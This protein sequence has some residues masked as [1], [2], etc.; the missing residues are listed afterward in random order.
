MWIWLDKTGKVKQYLTHG[1]SPVVGETDFQIFAYFDGL[2]TDYFDSATI[3]FRKPDQQGS[4]YPVLFMR[5]VEMPYE[6]MESDGSAS[7]FKEEHS[8]YTGFLFDF[9]DFTDGDEIIRLLDTPGLWEATITCLGAPNKTNVSGLIT[10][11]VGSAAGDSEEQTE[12]S[13]DQILENLLLSQRILKKS[14]TFYVKNSDDF[15]DKAENGKL[16][17]ATFTIGS[18]VFD[19]KTN[20]LYKIL[21]VTSN[22]ND[23]SYVYATYEKQTEFLKNIKDGTGTG[24]LNQLKDGDGTTF[25]FDDANGN[26][27]NPNAYAIDKSIKGDIPYGGV[28]NYATSFGGKSSAQGKRSLAQGT[29][30][31]AKGNYSHAE[32]DNSVALGIESHAEGYATTAAG[33]GSHTEGNQTQTKTTKYTVPSG[34]GS[35]SGQGG[36]ESGGTGDNWNI[37]EHRGEFS[38]AEGIN[39]IASGFVS[40]SEGG[41]S[42]ADGHVSHAE[43]ESTLASGRGAKSFGYK[44]TASGDYSVAGGYASEATALDAV[45]IGDSIHVEGSNSVAFGIGNQVNGKSSFAAGKAN[46]IYQYNNAENGATIGEGLYSYNGTIVLGKYNA[47]EVDAQNTTRRNVLEIGA[48]TSITARKNALWVDKNGHV[49]ISEVPTNNT[50]VVNK[51]YV[52]DRAPKDGKLTIQKNGTNVATFTANQSGDTIADISVPTKLSELT[53]DSAFIKNNDILLPSSQF[54]NVR[55]ATM[56]DAL[57]CADKRFYVIVSVHPI[58]V[59]GVTYPH[60][61]TSKASTDDDYIVD[62]TP[63]DIYNSIDNDNIIKTLF[64]GSTDTSLY[65]NTPSDKYIKV[66]ILPVSDRQDNY[67]PS[68]STAWFSHYPYG[69]FVLTTYF[70]KRASSVKYACYNKFSSSGLGW[71]FFNCTN[72]NPTT[73]GV[74]TWSVTDESNYQRS[75]I[76]FWFIGIGDSSKQL[77]PTSIYW[78]KSR[79]TDINDENSYFSKYVD[80]DLVNDVTWKQRG[81]TTA[82]ISATGSA[83][84]SSIAENGTSLSEKYLNKTDGENYVPYTGA[85]KG[86]SLFH[87]ENGI[88]DGACLII[89][90]LD[91]QNIII[92]YTDDGDQLAIETPVLHTAALQLPETSSVNDISC[93]ANLDL[94]NNSIKN[95]TTP[96]DEKDATNKK[97]VDDNYVPYTGATKDVVLN[98]HSLTVKK[99]DEL[100]EDEYHSKILGDSISIEDYPNDGGSLIGTITPRDLRFE[101]NVIGTS[102]VQNSNGI[103]FTDTQEDTS[104]SITYPKDHTGYLGD[105]LTSKNDRV[106]LN[107]SGTPTSELSEIKVGT[108]G[109]YSVFNRS[110][111]AD[112]QGGWE[113]VGHVASNEYY[114]DL[115]EIKPGHS[116]TTTNAQVYVDIATFEKIRYFGTQ[117]K[118]VL[119]VTCRTAPFE[120]KHLDLKALLSN[121]GSK[122]FFPRVLITRAAMN[123]PAFNHM[124]AVLYA[125]R[126]KVGMTIDEVSIFRDMST[127]LG[128]LN[129]S[130]GVLPIGGFNADGFSLFAVMMELDRDNANKNV[131][132]TGSHHRVTLFHPNPVL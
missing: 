89:S 64:D 119:D 132:V 107:P 123:S 80:E 71:K 29:T 9:A 117:Y 50:D 61:D 101:D 52:D 85:N 55:I 6:H 130:G 129:A 97:Y 53:N 95:L 35:G 17:V 115:S 121:V 18:I 13:I 113:L 82:K 79:A 21:T 60:T 22:P 78:L 38:H 34:S 37:E 1:G 106:T 72:I 56:D 103:E 94:T 23:N 110:T 4:T 67:S 90:N 116:G 36:T 30:T 104:F 99:K 10:F 111:L 33:L 125:D 128:T 5:K 69:T 62:S 20:K 39:T 73:S 46:I 41:G 27:K 58:I 127:A 75:V 92:G 26:S 47:Q 7:F 77:S 15:I 86:I 114:I 11:S 19:E 122:W 98:E 14:S 76:D 96:V 42:V 126:A 84:F 91:N 63:T 105:F 66:R 44:T 25:S 74:E 81:V 88:E 12:L 57:W 118:T 45:A 124:M 65:L 49:G 24:A 31:I 68:G 32:G 48:G 112:S 131:T 120:L 108:S 51:K 83:N 54:S 87:G 100:G 28:G 8:P 16:D 109:V 93:Y 3:K 59:N 40:H 70:R 43:G 102:F 2:D